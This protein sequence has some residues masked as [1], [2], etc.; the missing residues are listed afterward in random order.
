MPGSL[1]LL[2]PKIHQ[3]RKYT[4]YLIVS[5][6]LFIILAFTLI[7]L[8]NYNKLNW[9]TYTGKF[10]NV[11][12]KYPTNW[13][14]TETEGYI[15]DSGQREQSYIQLEKKDKTAYISITGSFFGGI[16]EETVKEEEIL[17]DNIKAKLNIT[18]HSENEP[19]NRF[20]YRIKKGQRFYMVF[21]SWDEKDDRKNYEVKEILKTFKLL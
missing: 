18:R 7:G 12:I 4:K 10:T 13:A 21:E 11:T 19:A 9:K 17:I 8:I 15:N 1:T 2:K 3:V 6:V 5:L 14:V 20:D 16:A